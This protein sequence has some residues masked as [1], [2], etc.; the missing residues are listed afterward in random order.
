M[1]GSGPSS[2]PDGLAIALLLD[3]FV[4]ALLPNKLKLRLVVIPDEVIGSVLAGVVMAEAR[5]VSS[6]VL[7]EEAG[8]ALVT[9]IFEVEGVVL[10]SGPKEVEAWNVDNVLARVPIVGDWGKA[11]PVTVTVF[12]RFEENVAVTVIVMEG[13]AEALVSMWVSVM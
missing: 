8:T 12:G 10:V 13:D 5:Y 6:N 1:F 3:R 9:V 2:I 11:V 4:I 7:V